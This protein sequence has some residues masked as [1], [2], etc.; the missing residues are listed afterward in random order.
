MDAISIAIEEKVREVV[1]EV[2]AT[3][4]GGFGDPV[5]I[6]AAEAMRLMWGDDG[7][8][9]RSTL[10]GII[11]DAAVNGFPVVRLGP[12]TNVIDKRRLT[13][14]LARGGLEA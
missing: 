10:A 1:A 6:S 9:H 7:F 12:K 3:G 5:M 14:W 2:L 11:R 4:G 8:D 13:A